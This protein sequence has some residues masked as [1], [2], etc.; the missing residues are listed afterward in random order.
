MTYWVRDISKWKH[1]IVWLEY[2]VCPRCFLVKLRWPNEF[3][4][5]IFRR[6]RYNLNNQ[7]LVPPPCV[8]G[9]TTNQGASFSHRSFAWPPL[10]Q[11][12][13]SVISI[14]GRCLL[15]SSTRARRQTRFIILLRGFSSTSGMI[16]WKL[17]VIHFSVKTFI[18][19]ISW[20]VASGASLCST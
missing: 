8:W 13:S 20:E 10:P 19:W 14:Y 7:H 4:K 1:L 5:N 16:S 18:S 9:K 11:S 15:I 6:E 3:K 12:S 2:N 17:F